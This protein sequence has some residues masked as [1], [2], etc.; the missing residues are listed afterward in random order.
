MCVHYTKLCGA[1]RTLEL[2]RDLLR[3]GVFCVLLGAGLT[4]RW[5]PKTKIQRVI[6]TLGGRVEG[7]RGL[8]VA[9]VLDAKGV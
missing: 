9:R 4:G 6:W 3:F 5:S 7:F 8:G 2:A 1:H